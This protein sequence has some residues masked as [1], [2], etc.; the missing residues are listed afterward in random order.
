MI[1]TSISLHSLVRDD[2][3]GAG[4]LDV[5]VALE[6]LA[7]LASLLEQLK[8]CDP[9][10]IYQLE[11]V[12]RQM[13]VEDRAVDLTY[14]KSVHVIPSMA[15]SYWRHNPMKLASVDATFG[16]TVLGGTFNTVNGI[17]GNMQRLTMMLSIVPVENK[18]N[19]LRTFELSLHHLFDDELSMVISDRDKGLTAAE[20]IFP[21]AVHARCAVHIARNIGLGNGEG[22]R[23][24][25]ALAKA[26]TRSKFEAIL[27]GISQ[28]YQGK[29]IV[30]RVQE[31]VPL[32]CTHSLLERF[33]KD[34]VYSFI[35]NY[36]IT[37]NNASE[38]ENSGLRFAFQSSC[39]FFYRAPA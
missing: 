4:A 2:T 12:N 24:I 5:E 36:G 22:L 13:V 28:K 3:K 7:C 34:S 23:D 30:E 9:S 25:T 26:P 38:Q 39:F 19:W 29:D 14:L 32:F 16:H 27:N 17:D 21:S 10:G 31:L 18:E 11:T 35:T 37:S 20:E 33:G 8:V 15:I 1:L 6:D